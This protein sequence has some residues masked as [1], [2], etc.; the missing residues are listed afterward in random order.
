MAYYYLYCCAGYIMH[1]NFRGFRVKDGE[2][3]TGSRITRNRGFSPGELTE[4]TFF[5][6]YMYTLKNENERLELLLSEHDNHLNKRSINH[7]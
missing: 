7:V 1:K 6:D 2:L 4:Y 3:Y 5:H